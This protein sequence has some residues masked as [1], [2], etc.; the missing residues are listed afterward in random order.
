MRRAIVLVGAVV[1]AAALVAPAIAAGPTSKIN[2]LVGDFDMLAGDTVIGH[3]KVTFTEPTDRK[4]V[5]GTLDIIWAPD[6]AD[7]VFPFMDLEW[8]P[9][10]ESHAQLLDAS[11]GP[12]PGYA[13]I[14]MTSGYLC[15]W[16]APWNADCRPFS[17]HFDRPF[18]GSGSVMWWTLGGVDVMLGIGEGTF[19]LIYGG[20]TS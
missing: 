6:V 4:L 5:P 19:T 10:K 2:K 15:D 3:I 17:V 13:L 16:T 7:D 11:F 9:V 8:K 1:L 14:G 18:D 12:E 20:P